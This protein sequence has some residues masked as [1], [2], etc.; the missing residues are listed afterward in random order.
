MAMACLRLVTFLPERPLFN[1]PFFISRIS[2]ST[3]LP[4]ALPYLRPEELFFAEVF[5]AEDFF[6]GV[7][8]ALVFFALAFFVAF[9]VDDVFAAFFAVAMDKTSRALE[10][11]SGRIRCIKNDRRP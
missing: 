9:F 8:F 7:F 4:A 11:I 10:A 3:C 6:A 1:V 5:F 2:V